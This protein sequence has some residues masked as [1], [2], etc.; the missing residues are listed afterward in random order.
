MWKKHKKELLVCIIGAMAIVLLMLLIVSLLEFLGIH[1]PGTREMWIGFIGAV[2]GGVFTLFGVLVTIYKQEESDGE[3][4][5]LENMPILG[6]EICQAKEEANT[7][8]TYVDGEMS[9]SCF[10]LYLHKKPQIIKIFVANNA[11]AFDLIVEDIVINGRTIKLGEAFNPVKEC[12]INNRYTTVAFDDEYIKNTNIFCVFRFSY[13]DVFGNKYFQD[14]P[15]TYFEAEPEIKKK[16]GKKKSQ[17]Q[18]VEIRDIKQPIFVDNQTPAL[19][20]TMQEYDD[21]DVFCK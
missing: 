4:R 21:Y 7:T 1:V 12:I 9:T 18:I 8:Y 10:E 6:F 11:C 20:N 5:R 17:K 13:T 15:F 16:K 3:K 14:L 2:I 19:V